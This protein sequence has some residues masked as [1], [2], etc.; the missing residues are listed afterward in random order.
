MHETGVT[1]NVG[2]RFLMRQL[3][4]I[5]TTKWMLDSYKYESTAI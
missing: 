5:S 4:R 3:L 2:F 1:L